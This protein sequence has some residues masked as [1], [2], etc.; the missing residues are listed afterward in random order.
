MAPKNPEYPGRCRGFGV[1]P[2][3]FGFRGDIDTY[4]SRKR[5]RERKEEERRQE[6]KKRLKE[7]EEKLTTDTEQRVAAVV[8]E[9]AQAQGL[10][11]L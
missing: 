2:W 3:K 6:L 8:N 1:V 7:H 5:R 9:M 4:R 11:L 10:P